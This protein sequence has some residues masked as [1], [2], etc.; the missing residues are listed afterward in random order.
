MTMRAKLLWVVIGIIV[1]IG[2][3]YLA[4]RVGN[5]AARGVRDGT[6]V[7]TLTVSQPIVPGVG[8]SVRWD[9]ALGQE[10]VPV[11]MRAR[12][13]AGEA[14]VGQGEFAAG[15]GLIHIP[16]AMGGQ[17]ISLALYAAPAGQ[18]AQLLASVA[19]EVLPAGPDC[20]R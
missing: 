8:V 12:S 4:N 20:L 10:A 9:T 16:C 3:G 15:Q 6:R 2:V 13:R 5:I 17:E 11:T 1:L 19:A 7:I 14:V 18:T